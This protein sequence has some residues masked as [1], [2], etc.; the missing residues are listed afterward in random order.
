M[1]IPQGLSFILFDP[2]YFIVLVSTNIINASTFLVNCRSCEVIISSVKPGVAGQFTINN[3]YHSRNYQKDPK[4]SRM[5]VVDVG[6]F[7]A[8]KHTNSIVERTCIQG[9]VPMLARPR[10]STF[11][12]NDWHPLNKGSL[13]TRQIRKFSPGQRKNTASKGRSLDWTTTHHDSSQHSFE[14]L[15]PRIFHHS[16]LL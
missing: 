9:A 15:H 16:L 13:K 12:S 7:S 5:W 4:N 1:R 11:P 10:A 14:D 6:R 8:L 3:I 2:T